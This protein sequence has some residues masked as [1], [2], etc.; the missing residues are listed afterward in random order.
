[1]SFASELIE[2]ATCIDDNDVDDFS[3]FKFKEVGGNEQEEGA[4]YVC[5]DGSYDSYV[6][7]PGRLIGFRIRTKD[8]EVGCQDTDN[9]AVDS[10]DYDCDAY[11][12]W[13]NGGTTVSYLCSGDWDDNDFSAPEMCCICNGG[14][15]DT[16]TI[17]SISMIVDDENCEEAYWTA[18][19]MTGLVMNHEINAAQT[20]HLVP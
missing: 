10:I 15:S 18:D 7:L 11:T 14:N 6:D 19:T 2:V 9:G 4:Q 20:T 12:E 8:G 17:R 16:T 13:I 5:D 1:M 3:R